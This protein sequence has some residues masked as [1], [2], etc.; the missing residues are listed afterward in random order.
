[1]VNYGQFPVLLSLAADDRPRQSVWP[2]TT[3]HWPLHAPLPVS[4]RHFRADNFGRS[5]RSAASRR[6]F[7]PC[8]SLPWYA[9]K[10]HARKHLPV[11]GT[12]WTGPPPNWA[13]CPAADASQGRSFCGGPVRVPGNMV[14]LR[15][16]EA[17][18]GFWSLRFQRGPQR[19]RRRLRQGYGEPRRSVHHE[20]LE[21]AS[22]AGVLRRELKDPGVCG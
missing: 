5:R 10:L 19:G 17:L 13:R 11:R 15:C 4:L 8:Q 22:G 1:M 3:E 18:S 12:A 21:A 6:D 14:Y 7:I 16:I 2:P 9:M 20:V